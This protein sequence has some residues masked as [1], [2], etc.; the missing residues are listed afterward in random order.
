MIINTRNKIPFINGT[1]SIIAFH[2]FHDYGHQKGG[3]ETVMLGE[4]AQNNLKL[5]NNKHSRPSSA[6]APWLLLS[7]KLTKN[8][9]QRGMLRRIEHCVRFN[10]AL[11]KF[12]LFFR[13]LWRIAAA[14]GIAKTKEITL[15]EITDA[16]INI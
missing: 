4:D 5:H 9:I 16:A 12:S 3:R 1:L 15:K 7:N 8:S 2:Q 10:L 14:I 6:D 11:G 13:I